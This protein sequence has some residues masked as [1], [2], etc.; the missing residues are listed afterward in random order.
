M[1]NKTLKNKILKVA[2][3]SSC[4]LVISGCTVAGTL[5]SVGGSYLANREVKKAKS[6]NEE[7]DD[8]F[9]NLA[10]AHVQWQEDRK[11][12]ERLRND[13][14]NNS[15]ISE[16]NRRYVG[17]ELTKL[18]AVHASINS[19]GV[20]TLFGNVPSETVEARAIEVASE[21]PGVNG[22]I[23]KIEVIGATSKERVSYEKKR[24]PKINKEIVRVGIR[25]EMEDFGE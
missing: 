21:I 12:L 17:G 18:I 25:N 7:A 23:S 13:K 6:K 20:V 9:R 22:V 14:A 24:S 4:A 1:D 2:L 19:D 5:A 10:V 3:L 8:K 16:L 15:V 11:E